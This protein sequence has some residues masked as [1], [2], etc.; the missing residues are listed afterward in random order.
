MKEGAHLIMSNPNLNPIEVM[1]MIESGSPDS[2]C[3]RTI[4]Y[5]FT[6][7]LRFVP[8]SQNSELVIN[9]SLNKL[10]HL[11]RLEPFKKNRCLTEWKRKID[12]FLYIT[13]ILTILALI[14]VLYHPDSLKGTIYYSHGS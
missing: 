7:K 8:G 4:Q 14:F 9:V 1:E 11:F 12:R 5:V 2:F 10:H 3:T 13:W 6:L